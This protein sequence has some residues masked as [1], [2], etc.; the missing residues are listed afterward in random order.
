MLKITKVAHTCWACPSQW[1]ALTIDN[2]QVYARFRWGHLS[3]RIGQPNDMSEFAAV[4]GD[5]IFA[6]DYGGDDLLGFLDYSELRSLTDGVIEWPD[7]A[8]LCL[9]ADW[10]NDRGK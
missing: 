10:Q 4:G 3:I 6:M 9:R 1:E 2:R 8:E 7:A 5:T